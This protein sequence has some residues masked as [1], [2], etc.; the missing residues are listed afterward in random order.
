MLTGR[1]Y[2]D[3]KIVPLKQ[4]CVMVK[5]ERPEHI[6]YAMMTFYYRPIEELQRMGIF[7][8]ENLDLSNSVDQ[9]IAQLWE[10]LVLGE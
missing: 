7:K 9:I 5:S 4:N 3:A 10:K 6:P 2:G 1:S 8:T